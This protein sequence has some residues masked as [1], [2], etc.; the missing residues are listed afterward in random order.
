M[1]TLSK[2]LN[3]LCLGNDFIVEKFAEAQNVFRYK[4]SDKK[5]ILYA[6]YFPSENGNGT[7]KY[8][9]EDNP[10]ACG[11]LEIPIERLNALMEFCAIL[12]D[13]S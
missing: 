6:F 3:L 10:D 5:S 4:I 9:V 8:F 2:A 12:S 11:G 1:K 7:F 13:L